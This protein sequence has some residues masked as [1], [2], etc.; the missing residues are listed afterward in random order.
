MREGK[1]GRKF[2]MRDELDGL[3]G[4]N[5]GHPDAYRCFP[6]MQKLAGCPGFVFGFH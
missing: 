2:T 3:A 6:E 1:N 5:E 4:K